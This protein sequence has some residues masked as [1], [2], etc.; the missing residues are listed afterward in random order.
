MQENKK[1]VESF[2]Q[3]ITISIFLL[4]ETY[5]WLIRFHI[6]LFCTLDL[7]VK[8]NVDFTTISDGELTLFYSKRV[9]NT[10][11]HMS[12]QNVSKVYILRL[13]Q[14]AIKIPIVYFCIQ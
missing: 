1:C 10:I 11:Y 2:E 14:E 3:K 4:G 12:I 9:W 6:M 13:L 7:Y 8:N 5:I